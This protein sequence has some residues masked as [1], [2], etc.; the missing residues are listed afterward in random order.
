MKSGRTPLSMAAN[1]GHTDCVRELLT[2]GA[3]VDLA[4]KVSIL[5]YMYTCILFP[6]AGFNCC[7]IICMTG[8]ACVLTLML[9][10]R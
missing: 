6:C 5:I 4:D 7:I 10:E 3:V 9:L 2:C 1:G 8:C